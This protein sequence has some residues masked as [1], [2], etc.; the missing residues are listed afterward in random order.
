MLVV[1]ILK[2]LGHK[3][4]SKILT[5]IISCRS[6]QDLWRMKSANCGEGNSATLA[7]AYN[8]FVPGFMC[9]S[10]T[11]AQRIKSLVRTHVYLFFRVSLQTTSF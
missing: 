5:K 9:Q 2:G 8:I 3:I 4:E 11:I 6:K 1:D 7:V 10:N